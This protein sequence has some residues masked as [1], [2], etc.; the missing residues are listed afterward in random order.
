MNRTPHKLKTKSSINTPPSVV[1]T[2]GSTTPRRSLRLAISPQTP[3][4]ED[5]KP[6]CE[7]NGDKIGTAK[8]SRR[9]LLQ[10]ER[11]PSK[12]CTVAPDTPHQP[13]SGKKSRISKRR[14]YYKKLVYD[15]GGFGVGDDVYV[16]RR[17]DAESDE[18]D[19]E[20]E[21]CRICFEIG[22]SLM[23]ECDNCLGGFHLRCL[24]PPLLEVPEGDWI[25][26]FCQARKLGKK[27][28]LPRPPDGKK[29]RR[30]AREKLLSS[31]LWAARIES[32]WKEPDGTYW[33]KCRWYVIPEET[34]AGR[35]PHNLRRELYLTNHLSDIEMESVLRHCYVMNPREFADANNEGDD[36]FYCEYEY[37]VR[38]HSFKRLAE[39]ADCDNDEEAGNDEDWKYTNDSGCDSEDDSDFDD[40]TTG[41]FTQTHELAANS[42]Q[43]RIFGLHKIGLKKIP[44]HVRL[45]KPT[46]LERAKSMLLL[47][48]LPKTLPCRTKE[49]EEITLFIKG[50]VCEDHCL[51]RCLYI[52]GVPGTGKTM[53]V[54]TVLKN[55]RAEVD[56][57]RMRPFCFVEVN[58]LKLSSP[59]NIYRVIYE[60]LSGHRVGWKKALSILNERFSEGTK[61]GKEENRPCVLL[62]D[63]LD[64]LLTR[65]QSVLYNILDWPT[66]PDSNLIIIGV[67]NTM[68]L[69]EKFLPRIS[70]RMGMQRLCFGPYNYQQ[71]QEIISS[72]LKGIDAFEE[73]AI[74]FASRKVAAMSGDARRALE[75]CRRAAEVADYRLKQLA[76]S[77]H[78]SSLGQ[79]LPEGKHFVSMDDV[80]AAIHEV[81]QA[82]HIRIMKTSSR[83]SKIMLAAM[84]HELYRSGL[85]EVT[86]EKLATTIRSL[87]SSNR[88]L[89]PGWDDLLKV[90]CK[91][92]ECRIIL[93]EEGAKH[94]LQRMQLNFPRLIAGFA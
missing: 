89:L 30:T 81:F 82:P 57:G 50:A 94:R 16:K 29:L 23:I 47:T 38:W 71:L 22:S 76:Q 84:V 36:V 77:S 67:A 56:A 78:S 88:E 92:G 9:S 6:N 49:M 26:E 11:T 54:L 5:C 79:S 15:G 70:S 65:N 52:H 10:P 60:A 73:Q 12:R 19:P 18:D 17:D 48:A 13:E 90:C 8:K 27:V 68:D 74:E 83:L 37:D 33:L 64:L 61:I 14:S 44:E 31:D 45:Y 2:P 87:C 62:V 85:G 43:G 72:R 66:K 39:V 69:P 58:G 80:E 1:R 32:L 34:P 91:L 42:R 53:T 3:T 24:R 46:D 51:G 55:L 63:E 93:S 4:S 40:D 41:K 25:C 59:E 35:Q 7:Y 20:A 28:K 21:E 86:F 75:I